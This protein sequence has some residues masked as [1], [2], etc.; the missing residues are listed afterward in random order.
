[1]ANIIIPIT[2]HNAD[3][4][5]TVQYDIR[6]QYSGTGVWLGSDTQ[7]DSPIVL[8]NLSNNTAYD[9]EITRNCCDGS[10]STPVT[11]TVDT[12]PLSAPTGLTPTQVGGDVELQWDDYPSAT[13][14]EI[15]RADDSGFTVNVQNYTSGTSDYTDS[16]P[17]AMLLYY[18]VR[19]IVNGVASAWANTSITVT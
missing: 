13:S 14:Y 9:I 17:P 6:W 18:R 8:N 1:M 12:T 11:F 7:F 19:A 10:L 16:T 4:V 5:C 15:Q 2:D 3:G